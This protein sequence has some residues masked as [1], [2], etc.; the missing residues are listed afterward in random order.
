MNYSGCQF[1][2]LEAPARD[3]AVGPAGLVKVRTFVAGED[4]WTGPHNLT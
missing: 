4:M 3:A 1:P 2:F